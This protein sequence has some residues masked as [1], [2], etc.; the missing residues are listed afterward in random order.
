MQLL[1]L[2]HIVE[3]GGKPLKLAV[4]HGSRAGKKEVV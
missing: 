3:H 4:C 2:G 1:R